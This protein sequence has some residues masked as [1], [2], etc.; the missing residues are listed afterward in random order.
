ML[1]KIGVT[2]HSGE[3]PGRRPGPRPIFSSV[4]SYARRLTDVTYWGPHVRAV[5]QR[6]GLP[7]QGI[8]AGMAGTFPA[9]VVDERYV[10]KLFGDLFDGLRS[11]EAEGEAYRL[12]KAC[13]GMPVPELVAT[14]R[15]FA[16]GAWSW[17]YLVMTFLTGQS[18]TEMYDQVSHAQRRALVAQLGG[19]VCQL[20]G[21]PLANT[22]PLRRSWQP[23]SGFLRRQ[24]AG[25][26]DQQIAWGTLPQHLID[27]LDAYVM[28]PAALIDTG[29]RPRLLHAD[30]TA[31]H[32]LLSCADG[33]WALS[34]LIDL[35]DACVGDPTYELVALHLDGLRCD[36][37]LLH[38]F[39]SSYGE[40]DA[41][42]EEFPRR[43][44]SY[45]LLH[46][47][48]VLVCL[49][50][51]SPAFTRLERLEDLASLLWDLEAP[52]LEIMSMERGEA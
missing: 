51:R 33:R 48:N 41:A 34:G 11:W 12:L 38:E 3:E 29:A 36:K 44:M 52:G 10:V 26:R 7:C 18:L 5:C 50:E 20:H 43:A 9:Y 27:Q 8:R 28:T 6:H 31:D 1:G 39:L 32:L 42:R 4:E 21:L 46:Q 23:T 24:Y 25:C 16:P 45:T 30:L 22:G 35:G 13:S 17:P 47:F 40:E 14:G 49:Q 2:I 15:L 19:L 37:R